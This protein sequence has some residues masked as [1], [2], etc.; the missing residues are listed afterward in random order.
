[1]PLAGLLVALSLCASPLRAQSFE[2]WA[3]KA[4]RSRKTGHDGAALADYTN[5][6]RA[7]TESDGKKPKVKVFLS[8]ADILEK[9]GRLSDAV[10]DL[11]AALS[12]DR[13]NAVLF[14]RR[15]EVY[16][17]LS[18]PS[19]AI[20]DFYKAT[21]INPDLKEAVFDRARAYAILGDLKF[22]REDYRTACDLGLKKACALGPGK[23]RR[24]ALKKPR[25]PEPKKAPATAAPEQKAAPPFETAPSTAAPEQKAA[26]PFE[27]ATSSAAPERKAAPPFEMATST[28]APERKDSPPFEIAPATAAPEQTASPPFEMAPATAANQEAL[29]APKFRDCRQRLNDCVAEGDTYS[30]CVAKAKDCAD[31]PAEGCCPHACLKQFND[32]LKPEESEAQAFREVFEPGG[33]CK[34][35]GPGQ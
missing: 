28:A 13:K 21:A 32:L 33:A 1:M 2:A 9:R 12:L 10:K 15:G 18:N 26:P 20:S 34:D 19:R 11:S 35:P 16:L 5:A 30:A 31:G 14:H 29:P 6:L 17:K 7:W 23:A 27:T 22:A 3:A 24:Y 25:A 4:E 8:R